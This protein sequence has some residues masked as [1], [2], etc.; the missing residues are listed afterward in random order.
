MLN[1]CSD[2]LNVNP[3]QTLD[4]NLLTSPEDADG[5]VTA[6]YARITDIPSWDSPFAPWWSGSMRS[7]DSTK[8]EAALGTVAMVGD[9][10]KPSFI[11]PPTAGR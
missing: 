4:E 5:F 11:L 6:A 9:T 2:F 10:W 1:S 3:K 8:P 7:D